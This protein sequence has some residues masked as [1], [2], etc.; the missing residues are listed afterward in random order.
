MA[1]MMQDID[2]YGLI[3]SPMRA[4]FQYTPKIPVL[5][6]SSTAGHEPWM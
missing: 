6:L 1:I 5:F 3:L 2:T 4:N